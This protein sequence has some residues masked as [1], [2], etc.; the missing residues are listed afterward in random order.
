MDADFAAR[1]PE[2]AATTLLDALRVSEY[3]RLDRAGHVYLDYTG[4]SLHA[5]SQVLRHAALLNEQVLGNPHS[6]SPSS[7]GMTNLVEQARQ[8][9]LNWFNAPEDEY[10]AVFTANA[11][12]ALKHVG[13][14]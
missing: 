14:S 3:G 2:Y 13:E 10:T 6:A 8:A 5:E 7:T 9:V 4:G 1:C 11:T 12:G